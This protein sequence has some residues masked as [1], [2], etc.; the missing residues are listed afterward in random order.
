MFAALAAGEFNAGIQEALAVIQNHPKHRGALIVLAS[1]YALSKD[2]ERARLYAR[3]L[4][5]Y[6]PGTPEA[7]NIE[8]LAIMLRPQAN[9]MDYRQAA[10][11]FEQAFSMSSSEIAAGLNLGSLYLEIGNA[12][13]AAEVLATVKSRCDGCSE[14]RH[15]LGVALTRIGR[16]DQAHSEFQ[17]VLAEN[18]KDAEALY[19]LALVSKNGYNDLEK[20]KG[21]LRQVLTLDTKANGAVYR[22]AHVMLRRLEGMDSR[23]FGSGSAVA[24]SRDGS[25]A[26]DDGEI[27][28]TNAV[29]K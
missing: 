2:F 6:H 28:R 27:L 21:Y 12:D 20:S 26:E 15:R 9:M 22:Q 16:F 4:E 23:K 19:R 13:K 5:R 11:M 24:Q 29:K 14:A 1:A 18:P 25:D 3:L 7:L 17:Q 10:T 8:A